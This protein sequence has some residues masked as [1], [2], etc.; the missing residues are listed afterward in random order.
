MDY[1]AAA[2]DRQCEAWMEQEREWYDLRDQ[3]IHDGWCSG[4]LARDQA[5]MAEVH[6]W[7]REHY[8][9]RHECYN[10]EVLLPTERDL[11]WVMLRWGA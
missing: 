7:L 9:G 8:Y 1:M 2:Y 6:Q 10:N 5:G 4:T 3:L 11:I